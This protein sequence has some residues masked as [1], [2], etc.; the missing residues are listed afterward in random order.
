[1]YCNTM[2][3]TDMFTQKTI[4]IISFLCIIHSEM[5]EELKGR[6]PHTYSQKFSEPEVDAV[7]N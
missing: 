4:I 1:M 7:V 5:E 2:N 6:S 3:Q